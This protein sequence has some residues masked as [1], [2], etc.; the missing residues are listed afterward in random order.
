MSNKKMGFNRLLSLIMFIAGLSLVAVSAINASSY[1]A[2]LGTAAFF[3]G[4]I[5]LYLTPT[6]HVPL[7]YLEASTNFQLDNIE[8]ILTE[9]NLNEKGIYLPPK[10]L[11]DVESSLIFIPKSPQT[12]IP[13]TKSDENLRLR[14]ND[15]LFL[16]PPGKGLLKVMEKVGKVSFTKLDIR[17]LEPTLKKILIEDFESAEKI[18]TNVK[19]NLTTIVISGSLFSEICN[20]ASQSPRAH[21]QVG[22]LFSS[23]LACALVKVIGNPI[24]IESET[25]DPNTKTTTIQFKSIVEK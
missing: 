8:R 20:Q 2:I 4:A 10:N 17:E 21:N 3:W 25:T 6:K 16:T 15:G 13:T 14:Q 19:Q 5:L 22:C 9:F 24:I 1:I 23:A 11:T 12:L 18:E 7:S